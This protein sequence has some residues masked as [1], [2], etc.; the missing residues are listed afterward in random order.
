MRSIFNPY[1]ELSDCALISI[2]NRRIIRFT[3]FI[4]ILRILRS[5]KN[6]LNKRYKDELEEELKRIREF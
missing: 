2:H 5:E 3:T 1:Y 4:R 6:E